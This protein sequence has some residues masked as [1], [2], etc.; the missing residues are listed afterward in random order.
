ME[1]I[2]GGRRVS[3]LQNYKDSSFGDD[4]RGLSDVDHLILVFF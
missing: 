3:S 2:I 4:H 1:E